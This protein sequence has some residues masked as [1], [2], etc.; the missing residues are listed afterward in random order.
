MEHDF[1]LHN[2]RNRSLADGNLGPAEQWVKFE[3]GQ[4]Y[5]RTTTRR[6]LYE[7]YVDR[8]CWSRHSIEY[9]DDGARYWFFGKAIKD[10]IVMTGKMDFTYE[11][12]QELIES[13]AIINFTNDMV[14]YLMEDWVR[15]MDTHLC[16]RPDSH[17]DPDAH[18][19]PVHFLRPMQ[20]FLFDPTWAMV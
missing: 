19:K 20:F 2:D 13:K 1:S 4:S 17:C 5:N 12:I 10:Y 16:D 9:K 7:Y 11:E 18:S 15:F 6:F 8:A 14:Y 3:K